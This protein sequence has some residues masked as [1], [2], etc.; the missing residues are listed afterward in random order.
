MRSSS[1]AARSNLDSVLAQRYYSADTVDSGW[2][3]TTGRFDNARRE[4]EI[5]STAPP[6]SG[7]VNAS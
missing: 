1:T 7:G 4:T 3:V 6:R 5:F 2:V